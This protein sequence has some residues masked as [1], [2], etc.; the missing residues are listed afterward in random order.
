MNQLLEYLKL[1]PYKGPFKPIPYYSVE[2]DFLT[3][4]AKDENCYAE[5]VDGRFIIYRSMKDDSIIG[6]QFW[7]ASEVFQK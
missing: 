5:N 7:N 4:Y 1:H 2:G 3:Y 6:F